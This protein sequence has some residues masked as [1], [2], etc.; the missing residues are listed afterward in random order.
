MKTLI[1]G[2]GEIG[3]AL[4]NV[5]L[6]FYTLGIQESMFTEVYAKFNPEILHICFG[7]SDKF[8]SEVK[9]YQEKYK[10]KYTVIHSTVPVG[11]SRQLNVVFHPI[12][13]QHPNLEKSLLTFKQFFGGKDV[14]NVIDYFRRVGMNVHIEDDP[15]PLEIGKLGLTTQYAL[16]VEYVKDLKKQYDKT[17]SPFSVYNLMVQEYN[18]GYEKLGFPEYK[19]PIINPIQKK[20]GGHC[21]IPNCDLWKTE[22]TEFIKN[23]NNK[24]E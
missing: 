5:L 15:E 24:Y 19:L 23:M 6:P 20:Q 18:K 4:A 3:K 10:P 17:K 8:V 16:N 13:G 21:T 14:H 22:F 12:I 7:Y 9:R 1:V 11:T 2:Y